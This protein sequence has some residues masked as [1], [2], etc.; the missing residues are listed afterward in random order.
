M[1]EN[2][3]NSPRLLMN[4]P[5]VY[6]LKLILIL[7]FIV[8]QDSHVCANENEALSAYLD[9]GKLSP[10]VLEAIRL[11]P[12]TEAWSDPMFI[13][14]LQVTQ[15]FRIRGGGAVISPRELPVLWKW[16]VINRFEIHQNSKFSASSFKRWA[17]I[18][19]VS[20]LTVLGVSISY[21]VP[22][23]LRDNFLVTTIISSGIA[24]SILVGGSYLLLHNWQ[25]RYRLQ[26]FII[27][28]WGERGMPAEIPLRKI[29]SLYRPAEFLSSQLNHPVVLAST[30]VMIGT[31]I[32][33]RLWLTKLVGL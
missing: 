27:K 24:Q 1:I 26:T 6:L 20:A 14:S 17:F 30:G 29:P 19:N 12:Q 2:R 15:R 18:G 28:R 3:L 22:P 8:N 16:F 23:A 13:Q 33:C 5:Y 10:E 7:G 32:S 11:S 31:A 9:T 25:D 4:G 21:F